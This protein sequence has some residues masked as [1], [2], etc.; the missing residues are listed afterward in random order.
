MNEITFENLRSMWDSTNERQR[1]ARVS[2]LLQMYRGDWSLQLDEEIKKVFMP[3]NYEKLR[4]RADT[5]FN[6][7]KWAVDTLGAIY[8]KPVL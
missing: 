4:L 8:A 5:S 6:I 2:S 3:Q 7:L 1:R